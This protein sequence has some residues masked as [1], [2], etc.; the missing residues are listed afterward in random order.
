MRE[1][2]SSQFERA[3]GV[4][5]Q[6]RALLDTAAKELLEKETLS[7]QQLATVLDRVQHEPAPVAAATVPTT[8]R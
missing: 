4:L 5:A 1:I 7:D 2:V 8:V 3:R 6:N